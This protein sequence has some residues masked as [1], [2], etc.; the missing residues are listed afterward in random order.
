[1]KIRRPNQSIGDWFESVERGFFVQAIG[2]FISYIEIKLPM[3]STQ[4]KKKK[5]KLHI[6]LK[7][8]KKKKKKTS[9]LRQTNNK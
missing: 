4:K 7:K 3:F 8:K 1:M 2:S 9:Q 6:I 5:I